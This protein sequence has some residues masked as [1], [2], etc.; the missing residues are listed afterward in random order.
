MTKNILLGALYVA[1]CSFVATGAHAQAVPA[2]YPADYA[3]IISKAKQEGSVAIYT[4]TDQAQ[5]QPLLEAFKAAY[6]G[7]EIQYNDLGTTGTFNRVISEAAAKQVGA[8]IVWTSAMDLQLVLVE[9]GLAETYKSPEAPHLPT[10]A[11]YKDAAYGTTIEPEAIVYNKKLLPEAQVPKT[12]AALIK[13]LVDNKVKYKG[14]TGAFD[15][16]KSG[17]GFIYYSHDSRNDK[18]FWELTRAFGAA[19]GKV[20]G[21]SGALREKVLS[22]E[23][24]LAFNVIGSYAMDWAKKA[25]M[26]GVV[27]TTDY[28]S[29]FSRVAL[30][31]KGAKHP[32]AA[33]LFLDFML[34]EKGQKVLVAKE[35]PSIRTDIDG[36]NLT[37]LNKQVGGNLIPI[38]LDKTLVDASEQKKRVEFFKE[39]KKNLNA[40][41]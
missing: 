28:T 5:S 34:S 22:G 15:P 39:W 33:R 21:S 7:I 17:T 26:M 20:Y 25:P 30:I 31:T 13:F 2:G 4:S 38:K 14:K 6:P 11:I 36:L 29:A 3:T 37:S 19:G 27:Y 41:K 1:A 16:E 23:H 9:R 35:I 12:R 32:N 18:R 10:W 40:H 8:D 24:V